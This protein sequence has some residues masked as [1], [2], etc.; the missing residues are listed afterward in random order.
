[1]IFLQLGGFE[2]KNMGN[3][4]AFRGDDENS[5]DFLP[6]TLRDIFITVGLFTRKVQGKWAEISGK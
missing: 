2:T 1:M 6:K 4:G 3:D 5:Y